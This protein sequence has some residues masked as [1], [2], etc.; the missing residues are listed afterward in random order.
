[1]IRSELVQKLCDDHPAWWI[2]QAAVEQLCDYYARAADA[3]GVGAVG[4]DVVL[5]S[6]E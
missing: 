2:L 1:M 5:A 3:D 6:E 4:Q